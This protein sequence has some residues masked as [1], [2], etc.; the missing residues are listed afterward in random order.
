M[1]FFVIYY[2]KGNCRILTTKDK[3]NKPNYPRLLHTVD[4]Y[5]L[6][7]YKKSVI[8]IERRVVTVFPAIVCFIL[9]KGYQRYR[10]F[11]FPGKRLTF[12]IFGQKSSE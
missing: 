6:K 5:R 7:S 12:A 11:L 9:Q 1:T 10:I 4:V 3:Y 2:T 8:F